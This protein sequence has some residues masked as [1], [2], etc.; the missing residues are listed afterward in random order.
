[1][2][3]YDRKQG[4]FILFPFLRTIANSGSPNGWA[5]R[6]RGYPPRGD[7]TDGDSKR[8]QRGHGLITNKLHP[9]LVHHGSFKQDK[10]YRLP[11]GMSIGKSTQYWIFCARTLSGD[12]LISDYR[13]CDWGTNGQQLEPPYHHKQDACASAGF[14]DYAKMTLRYGRCP[15]GLL[16]ASQRAG[17]KPAPTR[18]DK[19][20]SGVAGIKA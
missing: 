4:S 3:P 5:S 10:V 16:R 12:I 20:D 9:L 8:K 13:G 11:S 6:S 14:G 2:P 7:G 18:R 1:V 17:L 15:I 19:Q